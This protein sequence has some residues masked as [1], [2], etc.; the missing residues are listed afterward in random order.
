MDSEV[1]A[2]L[3]TKGFCGW[4]RGLNFAAFAHK[5]EGEHQ[6][7]KYLLCLKWQKSM[8]FKRMSALYVEIVI[9]L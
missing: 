3:V 8:I 1:H 6:N 5:K 4:S 2:P 9:H 7:F